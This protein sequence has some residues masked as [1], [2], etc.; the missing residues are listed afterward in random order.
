MANAPGKE[1]WYIA[2]T[3]RQAK[4]VAW[5]Q[6][7]RAV[8]PHI[9]G[10]DE[11]DLSIDLA[12]GGRVALRGAE[13]YDALRGPGLDGVI[14]GEF[15]DMPVEAWTEVV[16]PMLSDRLGRA[17]FIGTPEGFNHFFEL[18]SAAKSKTGWA[19]W[20]FT[21]LQGGNVAPEE[22]EAA[23][24]DLDEKT[25]RQEYEAS[26]ESIGS[27]RVYYAFER[28]ANVSPVEFDARQPLCWTLDFNIDPMCS[29]LA[30]MSHH[31]DR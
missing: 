31:T 28:A 26:F 27:G 16:R 7:K 21:T 3:Y 12:W 23:R 6:L 14:F 15:A 10:K 18:Y 29:V 22:V 1:A 13:N 19:S 9:V 2:P 5:R 25:F 17:L 20:Q 4:Q 11:T 24:Y 8:R 30:R